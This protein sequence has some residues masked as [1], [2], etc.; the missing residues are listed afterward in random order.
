MDAFSLALSVGTLSLDSKDNILLSSI[1][2][3]FHFFMPILGYLLGTIVVSSLHLNAHFIEAV[4]FLYIAIEMFKD[5]NCG[6]PSSFQL[7]ILGMLIFAFGVSL[8]SFGVGFVLREMK[9]NI[10]LPP[11]IFSITSFIFTF[12]GLNLGKRINLYIGKY[13]IL[14]GSIIMIVLSVI[15]FVNFC[16]NS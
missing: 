4:I 15:N 11:L 14:F 3:A 12:L 13:S 7:S 16:V 2:G 9:D 1:V 10:I 5:F 8:D 6:K